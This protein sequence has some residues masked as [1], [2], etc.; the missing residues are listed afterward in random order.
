MIKFRSQMFLTL[1]AL[2]VIVLIGVGLILGQLFKTYY[3]QNFNEHLEKET[4]LVADY[5]EG[6]GGIQ[7]SK[8]QIIS[9]FSKDLDAR[10][11]II[12]FNGEI[13]IDSGYISPYNDAEFGEVITSVVENRSKS[14]ATITLFQEIKTQY[15]WEPI[16]LDG[17]REGFVLISTKMTELKQAYTHMWWLL[18]FSFCFAF[19]VILILGRNIMNRYTKPI[20]RATNVAFELAKGNYHARTF[21]DQKGEVGMLNSSLNILARNLQDMMKAHE[22]QKDRLSTLIENVGSGLILIDGHGYI[23]L[24]NRTYKE[25]FD[26]KSSEYLYKLYYEV[27][28]HK[29]VNKIIEDIFMTEQKVRKQLVIPLKIER[30]HF[31]VYG[32]PIIGTNDVWKGILLVFHDITE[33][34]KLEQ[35]RKDFVANVSHELKTPVTSIKGF[36]E[37]L[38]DGAMEEKETLESFLSIILKESD[39]LQSLI[40][41]I[42]ELSKIENEGFSLSI[43]HL[44]LIL[45]LSETIKIIEGKATEKGISITFE[46]PS[47][48]LFIEGDVYR[49]KQVFINIIS[50]AVLYSPN[51]GKVTVYLEES[52]KK[53]IIHVKDTG[54]GIEKTEIPRIFERFYRVNKA[55]DRNSGGTGLGLAIVKHLMEAHKGKVTVKS[56]FG[57]G[58]IFSI[59]LLKK[60]PN[61]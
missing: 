40:Y 2:L 20:E 14:E 25:V 7:T 31:E 37:T 16:D 30:R 48:E 9:D 5:V 53:V 29:E 22:M 45:V 26:V 15:Y 23:N 60:F 4:R 61:L 46:K 49:L 52:P 6:I 47:D 32:V 24:I 59:E 54:M 58:T 11:T 57:K 36:T 44:N 27:I 34:K 8:R 1:L 10:I 39:R 21:E 38:L 28:K 33:I 42:L 3:F 35:M 51:D 13:V 43:Q 41:D 18:T 17:A 12:D 50:N 55:R 19:I 56:E